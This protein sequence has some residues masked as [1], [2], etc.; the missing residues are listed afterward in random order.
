MCCCPC[1]RDPAPRAR[2]GA[3]G[4]S[5]L[6]NGGPSRPSSRRAVPSGVRTSPRR[7]SRADTA[8]GL[9]EARVYLR[10][11]PRRIPAAQRYARGRVEALLVSFLWTD[12]GPIILSAGLETLDCR[13]LPK[14]LGPGAA[15]AA[16]ASR[17]GDGGY[18]ERRLVPSTFF[19]IQDQCRV[20]C[21]ITGDKER[22]AGLTAFTDVRKPT[23]S[24][25]GS[26]ARALGGRLDVTS[27]PGAPPARSRAPRR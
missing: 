3:S 24:T 22:R 25:L 2:P 19:E 1:P 21:L 10:Q 6:R 8:R 18:G 16:R 5:T 9:F 12:A 4:S 27:L 14:N 17:A 13:G 26:V 7:A 20:G 15:Q 11:P 23:L